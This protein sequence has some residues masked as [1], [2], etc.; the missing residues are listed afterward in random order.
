MI[1]FNC[2]LE[3]LHPFWDLAVGNVVGPQID[4]SL[5]ESG[6]D[7]NSFEECVPGLG[8]VLQPFV[9]DA[10][11]IVGL[12]EMRRLTNDGFE[13]SECR[14]IVP[15]ANFLKDFLVLGF[16]TGFSRGR[17]AARK[18]RLTLQGE[19]K[20]AKKGQDFIRATNRQIR[21]LYS[22]CTD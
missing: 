16:D 3:F 20:N 22:W 7:L 15:F 18:D 8:V 9:A 2:L 10:H 17:K 21:T 13:I 5:I 4:M 12:A 11:Q 19:D 1:Q 14:T 6:I